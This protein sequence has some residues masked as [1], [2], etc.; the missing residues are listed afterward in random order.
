MPQ[1]TDQPSFCVFWSFE[2]ENENIRYSIWHT[3]LCKVPYNLYVCMYVRMHST[4]VLYVQLCAVYTVHQSP[5]CIRPSI[6]DEWMWCVS[7]AWLYFIAN[8]LSWTLWQWSTFWFLTVSPSL[9]SLDL[10]GWSDANITTGP[11]RREGTDSISCSSTHLT[12]FAVLVDVSG[13]TNVRI[14]DSKVKVVVNAWMMNKNWDCE[15]RFLVG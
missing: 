4:H 15:V 7:S 9:C 3:H 2:A 13:L 12:T 11:R 1:Y 6:Q 10:G 8:S 5:E 14:N